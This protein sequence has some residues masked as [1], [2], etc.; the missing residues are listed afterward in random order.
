[1][2]LSMRDEE[3]SASYAREESFA[4][5]KRRIRMNINE[6]E[7]TCLFTGAKNRIVFIVLK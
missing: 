7:L 6:N 1:M 5:M 4:C 2:V 3:Y